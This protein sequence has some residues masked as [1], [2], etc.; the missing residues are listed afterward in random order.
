VVWGQARDYIFLDGEARNSTAS[1]GE[2]VGAAP[3]GPLNETSTRSPPLA[4]LL[5]PSKLV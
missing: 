3:R 5:F 4:V 1:G 2:R